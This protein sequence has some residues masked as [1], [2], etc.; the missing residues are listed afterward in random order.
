MNKS[1]FI[2]EFQT[3]DQQYIYD[4][5]SSKIINVNNK[6]K[7]IIKNFF[8]SNSEYNYMKE[9]YDLTEKEYKSMRNYINLLINKY[10]MFYSNNSN[11]AYINS[12]LSKNEIQEIMY[13]SPISQLI[14]IVTNNCNLR[15][16]YCV[17]SDKYPKDIGYSKLNMD[18]NTAKLAIDSFFELNKERKKRGLNKDIH[19]S[20]YGGEPLLN[21]DLIKKSIGYAKR[22]NPE[23]KFYI[24]TNGT[25]MNDEIADFLAN[26]NIFITFSL[27]GY[28]ENHDRNRVFVNNKKSFDMVVSNIKKL[29]SVKKSLNVEMP[30]TFNCCLD[31]YTDLDKVVSFFET[32][33]YDFYPFFTTFSQI[34]PF[35]T[36]YYEWCDEQYNNGTLSLVKD[37]FQDSRK[38]VKNKFLNKDISTKEYRQVAN[39]IFFNELS[40]LIRNRSGN[41]SV[42]KNSCLPLSKIAV[43]PEGNL[44]LCEKMCEKFSV[45]DINNGINWDEICDVTNKIISFFSSE[46]CTTCEAKSMCDACFMFLE[47]DGTMSKEFCER[48]VKSLKKELEDHL[49]LYEEEADIF[50]I[51]NENKNNILSISEG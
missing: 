32:Y 20:F 45:G 23:T 19:I 34:K 31:S 44:F 4:C 15:C 9:V 41:N 10:N 22:I 33:Y 13:E 40:F 18:F 39:A 49:T 26:N 48:R 17:Y 50:S 36:T 11:N 51:L 12:N 27:D 38:I 35:N 29:Q 6:L 5:G 25:I 16:E 21:F 42:L 14:L 28:K 3:K 47:E 37:A 43:S 8:N 30:I 1:L 46:K 2:I 7:H 24:T